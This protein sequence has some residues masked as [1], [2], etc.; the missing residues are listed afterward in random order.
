[1]WSSVWLCKYYDVVQSQWSLHTSAPPA[2]HNKR[3]ACP[4]IEVAVFII[5]EDT[6]SS[7]SGQRCAAARR[8]QKK[9]GNTYQ[10]PV[11]THWPDNRGESVKMKGFDLGPC[12]KLKT[13]GWVCKWQGVCC[14]SVFISLSLYSPFLA[15]KYSISAVTNS[16]GD[17]LIQS[18]H[19]PPP[20]PG[21]LFD[22]RGQYWCC[23]VWYS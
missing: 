17:I 3:S 19:S 5:H 1:M 11:L 14:A 18:Q 13:S 15:A 21:P 23:D 9:C 2:L 10:G 6:A 16:Q 4:G 20:R 12:L 8:T 7:I 22:W